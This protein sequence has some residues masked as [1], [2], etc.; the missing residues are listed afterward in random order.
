MIRIE[1]IEIEEF[2]GIKK[3]QLPLNRNNYGVCGPNGTGKSGIVDAIEFVLTG[4]I[5]RLTGSGSEGLTIKAHAPHVD[6]R[7]TPEKS[8]VKITAY[9]P[10]LNKTIT[11]ER[12]VN[13][14]G[15]PTV[16]PDEPKVRALVA[17]LAMHPE[18][19]LSRREIVK[20]VITPV[21]QR[22]KDVQL[23]LR[24]EQIEKIRQSLQRVANDTRKEAQ[25]AEAEDERAK[26]QLLQHLGILTLSKADLLKAVNERRAILQLVPLDDLKSETSLK[27]GVIATGDKAQPTQRIAKAT[28]IADLAS[29]HE[30]VSSA[31]NDAISAARNAVQGILQGLKGDPETLR[32]FK[33]QILVQQGLEA[34]E[35]DACP[36]CDKAWDRGEL[37]IHLQ[38]KLIKATEAAERLLKLQEAAQ[39]IAENLEDLKRSA[40]KITATC[41]LF[42]PKIDPKP[43]SEFIT[44]CSTMRSTIEQM[45]TDPNLIDAALEALGGSAWVPVKA[46]SD[47]MEDLK[48]RLNALPEPSKEDEARDFLIVAQERYDRCRSTK[49]EKEA[50]TDRS[51]LAARVSASYGTASNTVL[52]GIYDTV[53]QDFTDYYR[54]INQDDEGKFDGKLT[55]SVGKLAFDV[56]FYGRG[57]FPPGAYH[58][59]G[60]QDGMGLCLYLALVKHTLGAEFTFAVL[61]DVLMSVDAGHRREVCTLLKTKFP[62]TQ[63]IL[64][65]HDNVWLKFMKTE[66]LIQG[67]VTFGGWSVDTGPQV[68]KDS[69]VWEQI[70]TS[71]KANDVPGAAGTLRRYLEYIAT[72][73]AD[74]FRAPVEFH[75]NGSYDLG[76]LLPSVLS[77]WQRLLNSADSSAKSWGADTSVIKEMVTSA[78]EKVKKSKAEQWMINSSVHF[79][80]WAN[81]QKSEFGAVAEAFRSLLD[82]MQCDVPACREFFYATPPKGTKE[83]LR[84]GCGK[85][86]LNLTMKS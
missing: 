6:A 14:A 15:S 41:A 78:S 61:D 69:D 40:A 38:Q 82:S 79:N 71:L 50:S 7:K 17:Q 77:T 33:R 55:P 47:K 63:F 10:S 57:K 16:L 59:E 74:N 8:S 20:Y 23:L 29:F 66:A 54:V 46:L 19:A 75:G 39:P 64:T 70:A 5:T 21:G 30:N 48:Q 43:L 81:L 37:E 35:E 76:D 28:A 2:R 86:N 67:S 58:S 13:A 51:T 34:L 12:R 11:I 32:S 27:E 85:T 72:V 62:K 42:D 1:S 68:W 60:H 65:T 44:A 25:S 22:A 52:E 80:E 9:A 49:A 83:A 84:C 24:L 4:D 18:F 31:N 73:L 45:C 53:Q 26:R 56:D 36:L 3:L